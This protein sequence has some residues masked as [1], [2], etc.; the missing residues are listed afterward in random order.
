MNATGFSAPAV[1]SVL[2]DRYQLVRHVTRGGMADVYEAED[3][4]LQRRV[5]VKLFRGAAAGDRARFDAEV[6]VLAAL[7]HP[8]L[9]RVY[10][11]GEQDG[12]AFVVLELIEG[13]TLAARVA[14]RG[15][16]PAAEVAELGA[17]VADALAF[18]HEQG[19][20]HRDV[21]PS[22]VLC[23]PDGRPR[24]ADFGIA[25]LVDTTRI[26]ATATAV[27]T[28]A[29]MAPEQVQGHDVTAAAD[30]YAL[31]LV[32]LELLTGRRA[33][34]G[35]PHEVAMARLARDPDT[36]T[37]VPD[38]WRG[39]LGEMTDRAA[40]NRPSAAEVRDRLTA[41]L[42]AAAEVTAAVAAA[43]SVTVPAPSGEGPAPSDAVTASTPVVAT[44]ADPGTTVMPATLLPVAEPAPRTGARRALVA[45]AVGVLLLLVAL[46]ATGDGSG[47]LE[48]PPT[49]SPPA[50]EP[51]VA[52]PPPTTMAPTTTVA[53]PEPGKGKG[54]PKG[55][56]DER[57]D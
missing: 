46:A 13:P 15:P 50:T 36:R 18:V 6:V 21:T 8:G 41:L 49:T 48:S 23:A 17:Q 29:F 51:V 42:T 5:A 52:V 43:P 19:V 10:D 3:R 32:L 11:A 22:N 7:N 54:E 57:D 38:A 26:T 20:V 35:A 47:R 2:V 1:G 34:S 28:A 24:L 40:P 4:Q 30:V 56:G 25:R 9:V 31:G 39:L 55:K 37:D 27:G 14:E 53:P 44:A 45:A 33:F 12:D 16:L